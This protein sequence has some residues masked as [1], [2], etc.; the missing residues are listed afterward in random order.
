[1]AS[2]SQKQNP[3]PFTNPQGKGVRGIGHQKTVLSF[4]RRLESRGGVRVAGFSGLPAVRDFGRRV[5]PDNDKNESFLM[6]P[7]PFIPIPPSEGESGRK[8]KRGG[9][10]S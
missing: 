5:K 3:L 10:P 6:T 1:M 8:R 2:P 4:Q 9:S 7:S